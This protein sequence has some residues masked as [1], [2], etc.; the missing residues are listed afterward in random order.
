MSISADR[1]LLEIHGL[2]SGYGRI[3]ILDGVELSVGEGCIL[4]ILGHNGMGKTT[5]LRTLVGQVKAT[6]GSIFFAGNDL[7]KCKPY[8]RARLGLGYVPQRREIFP[9]LSA[10]ENLRMG[11]TRH[12]NDQALDEVLGYFPSLIPLLDRPGKGLSGG[13]QQLLALARCLVGRPKLLM[14]D[15]PTEGIQPSIIEEIASLLPVLRDKFGLTVLLVEQDLHFISAVAS[16][17]SIIQKGR[18][19]KQLD[20]HELSNHDIIDTYLGV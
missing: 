17:V 3:R 13:Q 18:I 20:P 12:R 11:M 4:G 10:L 14:L 1:P 2:R 7:V 15:E 5:L 9:E 8:E 6:E 16:Q 19:V